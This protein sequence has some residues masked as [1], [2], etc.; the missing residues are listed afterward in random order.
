M[1]VVRGINKTIFLHV[2]CARP[3]ALSVPLCKSLTHIA[4]CI[5]LFAP[6]LLHATCN[7]KDSSQKGLETTCK[8]LSARGLEHSASYNNYSLMWT[9]T[10][11]VTSSRH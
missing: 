7:V 5:F 2:E 6:F 8:W 3:H 9:G 11:C 10:G 4:C 1:Q